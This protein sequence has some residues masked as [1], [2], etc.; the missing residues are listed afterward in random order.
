[1]TSVNGTQANAPLPQRAALPGVRTI[2][3]GQLIVAG[4]V[5]LAALVAVFGVLVRQ[6]GIEAF[7]QPAEI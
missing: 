4:T 7:E 3:Q 6:E 2:S 5:L 1:M